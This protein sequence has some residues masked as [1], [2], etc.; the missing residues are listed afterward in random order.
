MQVLLRDGSGV[1][2]Y[3]H[4]YEEMD[5]HGNVRIYYRKSRRGNRIRM[6]ERPGT[7]AFEAEYKRAQANSANSANSAKSTGPIPGSIR[8]LVEK[9]Y[10]SAAFR[11]LLDPS[12]QQVRARI[13]ERICKRIGTAQ[14]SGLRTDQI[15][16]LRDEKAETPESANSI[17]KALRQLFSWACDP[18]QKL[19]CANPARDVKYLPPKKAG[20]HT[21]WEEPHAQRYEDHWQLGTKQRLLFDFF[22]YTGARISDVVKFGPQMVRG[23]RLHFSEFK[24]RQK[25]PKHHSMRIL[26]PLQASIDAYYKEH[27]EAKQHLVFMLTERGQAHTTKGLGNYFARQCHFAGIDKGLSAHGIRKLAAIRCAYAGASEEEL[28]AWFGWTPGSKQAAVYTRQAKRGRLE[29]QTAAKLDRSPFS[30]TEPSD[31]YD[32]GLESHPSAATLSEQNQENVPHFLP[33]LG[34]GE[35]QIAKRSM[36]STVNS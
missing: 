13:L 10:R 3:K 11:T 1:R 22:L 35:G 32:S 6:R 14:F 7:Q 24:G 17:V 21:P 15:A 34:S 2:T 12:T 9:Y 20:G 36:K 28:G 5:R 27:P 8:W 4:L 30:P 16:R 18:E 31:P 25:T 26:G 33:S 29:D 19:A 23:G